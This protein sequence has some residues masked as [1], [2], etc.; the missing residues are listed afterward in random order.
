[1]FWIRNF[2]NSKFSM[3]NNWTNL[4]SIKRKSFKIK[5]FKISFSKFNK[6]LSSIFNFSR[7]KF[8]SQNLLFKTLSIVKLISFL[9]W[10]SFLISFSSI[11]ISLFLIFKSSILILISLLFSSD[12]SSSSIKLNSSFSFWS[13]SLIIS[14]FISIFSLLLL[15][16]LFSFKFK[17]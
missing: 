14:T 15:L 10:N 6:K 16:L 12:F 9:F 11:S 13:S 17:S 5:I 4:F 8:W 2:M 1:M 3:F 7:R